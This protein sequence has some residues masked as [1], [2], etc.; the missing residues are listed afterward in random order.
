VQKMPPIAPI[1]AKGP[2]GLAQLPRLWSKVLLDAKGLLADG[3]YACGP[4]LDKV[5]LD[6][7]GLDRDEVVRYLTERLPS[8]FEFEA[9]VLER[10]GGHLPPEKVAAINDAILGREFSDE[11]RAEVLQR[12]GLPATL[13]ERKVSELNTY[14][15]WQTFHQLLTRGD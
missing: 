9:W 6:G 1:A 15:D 13:T 4:G 14:D 12:A 11:R 5:L 7:L 2:L 10:L 3:Y 8:Y